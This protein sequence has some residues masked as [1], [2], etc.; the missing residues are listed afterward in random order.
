MKSL[1]PEMEAE[2]RQDRRAE[3]RERQQRARDYLR[4]RDLSWVI[5]H[6]LEHGPKTECQLLLATHDIHFDHDDQRWAMTGEMLGCLI[7]LARVGKLWKASQGIHPG[8]GVESFLFGI[9][10]VHQRPSKE[11]R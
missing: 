3:R 8:A 9:R 1:F 2:I 7:A 11:A 10:G 5:N 4:G 6:L